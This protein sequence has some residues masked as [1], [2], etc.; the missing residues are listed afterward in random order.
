M[1]VSCGLNGKEM[2]A[3]CIAE[4]QPW[5]EDGGKVS[6]YLDYPIK[7]RLSVGCCEQMTDST[8]ESSLST[9]KIR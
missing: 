8:L 9:R 6:L 7:G 3:D 2:G 1:E 4:E 5:L